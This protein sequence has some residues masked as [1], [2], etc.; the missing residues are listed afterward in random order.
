MV[1]V[2]ASNIKNRREYRDLCELFDRTDSSGDGRVTLAEFM[3][4]CNQCGVIITEEELSGFA[5]IAKNGEVT[6]TLE[7][8]EQAL[9]PPLSGHQN[10]LHSTFKMHKHKPVETVLEYL[11]GKRPETEQSC[12]HGIQNI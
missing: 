12:Q 8:V 7:R 1:S 6:A 11:T 5:S 2:I 10:R 4:A 3:A 9:S